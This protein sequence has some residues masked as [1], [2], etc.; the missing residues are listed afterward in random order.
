MSPSEIK[1]VLVSLSEIKFIP[2]LWGTETGPPPQYI[3][4]YI[5]IYIYIYYLL[6][7]TYYILPIDCLLIA[8]WLPLMHIC[9]AIM[10]MGPGPGPKAQKLRYR[11][12]YRILINIDNILINI[13]HRFVHQSGL[14][15]SSGRNSTIFRLRIALRVYLM[16]SQIGKNTKYLL[17]HTF[18]KRR[19]S[20]KTKNTCG[21]P[22]T[23]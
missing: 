17:K 8:Y 13:G 7:I 11:T 5:Y 1:W 16:F 23:P 14:D 19:M 12:Q 6:Y 3:Y 15:Q 10:D 4:T 21:K 18:F 22:E 2:A 9:S 20:T